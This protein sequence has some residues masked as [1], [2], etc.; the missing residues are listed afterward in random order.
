MLGAPSSNAFSEAALLMSHQQGAISESETGFYD[1]SSDW[2]REMDAFLEQ[3]LA[4]TEAPISY[5][6]E[7]M[8]TWGGWYPEEYYEDAPA[9]DSYGS[10]DTY[11]LYSIISVE[12][13]TPGDIHP[14]AYRGS[15]WYG[16][17]SSEPEGDT[18]Y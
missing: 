7:E 13:N 9:D 15:G 8:A 11:Y 6:E 1:T 17:D 14:E 5:T 18:R 10:D 2:Y 3:E 12:C 4:G 16:S